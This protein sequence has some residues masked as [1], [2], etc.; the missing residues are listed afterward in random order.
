[1]RW[2]HGVR[3]HLGGPDL[4]LY[5]AKGMK[6][7]THPK[8]QTDCPSCERAFDKPDERKDALVPGLAR[9]YCPHCGY[10]YATW[11]EPDT[12]AVYN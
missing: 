2:R 7:P 12:Y 10:C 9:Y 6:M 1:V 11:T 3:R 8:D 4:S 5:S